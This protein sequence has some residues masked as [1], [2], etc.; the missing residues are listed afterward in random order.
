MITT[1]NIAATLTRPGHL[2]DIRARLLDTMRPEDRLARMSEVGPSTLRK[3]LSVM[4]KNNMVR[5]TKG[6]PRAHGRDMLYTK[7]ATYYHLVQG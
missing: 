4:V 3:A 5:C 2:G 7:P 6:L 1:E